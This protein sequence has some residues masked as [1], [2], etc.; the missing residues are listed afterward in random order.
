MCVCAGV[1]VGTQLREYSED[2]RSRNMAPASE[3]GVR[4]IGQT[5]QTGQT[6]RQRKDVC[7]IQAIGLRGRVLRYFSTLPLPSIFPCSKMRILC[8]NSS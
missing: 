2:G 4:L 8:D 7:K 6:E 3:S 1:S 5:G